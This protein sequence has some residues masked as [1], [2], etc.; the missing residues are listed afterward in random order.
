[1]RHGY[2]KETQ[3]GGYH[4]PNGK[5]EY[6]ISP[7]MSFYKFAKEEQKTIYATVPLYIKHVAGWSNTWGKERGEI[8]AANP[9]IAPLQAG[10]SIGLFNEK[11][12]MEAHKAREKK[13]KKKRKRN[14]H[15]GAHYERGYF[16]GSDPDTQVFVSTRILIGKCQSKAR[17]WAFG[18]KEGYFLDYDTC[19][20]SVLEQ[21]DL[22]TN[23]A[24]HI[25][26][27]Q[28]TGAKGLAAFEYARG[29]QIKEKVALHRSPL[30]SDGAQ[31]APPPFPTATK[32]M[33]STVMVI[34]TFNRPDCLRTLLDSVAKYA[35]TLPV[36]IADDSATDN[37]ALVESITGLERVD[38]LRLPVD[39]GVGYGRNQ[40]VAA[41][42]KRGFQYLIMSDDDYLIGSAQLV[43]GA[44][45][46]TEFC[47]RGCHWI[48]RMFA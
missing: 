36:I 13:R 15:Y 7:D 29:A 5:W 9:L 19:P 40:L 23:P 25:S 37:R 34:K 46:W 18:Y 41:A 28:N 24:L 14:R 16:V 4:L 10:G 43:Y 30:Q 21:L 39:S 2:Y 12:R 8:A 20:V 3:G 44:R 33:E 35:P 27:D 42:K 32:I 47:T 6:A 1:M 11:E 22:T 45:F 26:A 17:T 38:Y 48:P 31:P